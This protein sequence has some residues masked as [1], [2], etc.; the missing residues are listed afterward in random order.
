MRQASGFKMRMVLLG[1]VVGILAGGGSAKADFTFGERVNLGPVVNSPYYDGDP[2]IAPDGLSLYFDSTRPG[3]LGGED[4]WVSTRA[5]VS[6]PWGPP[7]SLGAPVNSGYREGYPSITADGLTLAFSALDRPGGLGGWDIWLTTRP[8]KESP[9]GPPVDLGSP[10][11]STIHEFCGCISPDG[12]SLYFSNS[13][14]NVG[15]DIYVTTR[16]TRDSP[17][18]PPARLGVLGSR[19]GSGNWDPR[20]SAD[21]LALFFDSDYVTA[22]LWPDI[23][24]TTRTSND[25]KWGT[26]ILLGPEINTQAGESTPS[27]S[28][29][30]STLYW[31]SGPQGN[32]EGWDLWQSTISPIV[33]FTGD[34]KVDTKD[35]LTLIEHWGQNDPLC[36]IGPMPWGDGKVDA[37]DLEV[38]MGYWGQEVYDSTLAHW[39]MDETSGTTAA[40]S[41]G[42]NNGTLVGNPTWQPTGGK[43]GGALQFDGV[44]DCVTMGFVRDPSEGP[45]SIFAWVKGGAPGQAIV[46]QIKGANW[47]MAGASDGG[48]TTE[49]SFGGR[50]GKQPLESAASVTDGDWHRVGFVW[51]GSNRALYVDDVEVAMDTQTTLVGTFTGLYV[52]AGSM[53]VPGSF[54]SGL[55][56]DVRIYNRAVRP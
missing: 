5:T 33:D 3:G 14:G 13:S 15:G 41:V 6:D 50:N 36:D 47:L 55:I 34:G 24:L 37:A 11:N 2:F 20:I 51:D 10:V 18:D 7:V 35:I 46:S 40:D 38:L 1:V 39:K 56:D 32:L 54:W 23:W 49:L 30:G 44:D 21:G 22:A 17:W 9:W 45:F 25:S 27:I 43:I 8:T 52:G 12:C 31:C 48:L 53:L 4:I 16:P 29:D 19:G 42:A 28:A 26:P